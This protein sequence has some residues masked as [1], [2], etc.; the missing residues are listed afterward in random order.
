MLMRK[1]VYMIVESLLCALTAGLLMAA[2]IRMY[3]EGATIQASGE[4]FYYI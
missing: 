2:A 4:L 1:K 3:V